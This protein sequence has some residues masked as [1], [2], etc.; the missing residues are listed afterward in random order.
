MCGE[1]IR[2]LIHRRARG[3]IFLKGTIRACAGVLIPLFIWGMA[4]AEQQNYRLSRM[5]KLFAVG[6][7]NQGDLWVAGNNGLLC[8]SSDKGKTFEQVSV[9]FSN[10]LNDICFVGS[11]GWIVGEQGLVL[12]SRDGG[13]H[14]E[15]QVSNA[16][17]SLMAAFF[18][19]EER[20]IAVGAQ[21]VLIHTDNGGKVWERYDLDFMAVLPEELI[22]QGVAAVN[23]YDIFF[24]DDS[25]G[26]IVGDYGIILHSEDGGMTWSTQ[27]MGMFN[28]LFCVL[29]KNEKEGWAVGQNG[30]VL[31]TIDG[32]KN[33]NDMPPPT[34][35]SLFKMCM[36][37][38][39]GVVVTGDKGTII[40]WSDSQASW[41]PVHSEASL[42]R[43]WLVDG[44]VIPNEKALFVVGKGTMSKV[45]LSQDRRAGGK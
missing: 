38:D 41:N 5:D 19:N 14:W 15:Q 6:F 20:G 33:W 24:V 23:F 28:H 36:L 22:E 8:K 17:N 7:C 12:H 3:S 30:T 32:G 11:K 39:D 44:C 45:E 21:S 16:D 2:E 25:H 35:V 26:W 34:D 27:R 18:L 43:S 31:R 37:E 29:F 10:S 40:Q 13:M 1:K 42:H 4:L 9:G